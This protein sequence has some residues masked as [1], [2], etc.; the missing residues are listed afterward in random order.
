MDT[1]KF[2]TNM[3]C[4]GCVSTVTPYLN[5]LIDVESWQADLANP[6]KIL[7]VNG[8]DGIRS[9]EVISAL[10]QAGFKAEEV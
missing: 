5:K 7:T 1:L 10:E 2:K 3:K 4:D 8:K 6:E 9:Q